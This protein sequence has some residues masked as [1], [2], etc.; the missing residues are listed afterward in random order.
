[1][2]QNFGMSYQADTRE[3]GQD[4]IQPFPLTYSGGP[5]QQVGCLSYISNEVSLIIVSPRQMAHV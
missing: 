4:F 5:A 1:M 2:K 3:S